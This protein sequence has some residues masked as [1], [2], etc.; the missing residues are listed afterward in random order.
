MAE[1]VQLI[2]VGGG[3][4]GT[5]AAIEG[6]RSGL[7]VTLVDEHPLDLNM[8]AQDIPLHFGQRMLGTVENRASML[9]RVAAANPEL[10][11]A[12]ELGVDVKL[13]TIVWSSEPN[14][15]LA[16]AEGDRSWLVEFERMI[17]ATGARD[18]G[19]AFP[20]W[21][22]AGVMGAAGAL[23]LMDRY[24]AFSGTSIAI[25]GSGDLGLHLAER[26]LE[27]GIQVVGIVDVSSEVR[28][29][30]EVSD[31]LESAGVP[32]YLSHRVKGA[33]GPGEVDGLA[34]EPLDAS[35][36][37]SRIECDTVCLAIGLVPSVELL[38]W[39]GCEMDY[40][41]TRGGFVPVLDEDQRTRRE[42][43]YV[44]GDAA[45]NAEDRY[46][47]ASFAADSG[48]RA[49][50]S[51]SESLG[52]LE[53]DEAERRKGELLPALSHSASELDRRIE[54]LES[55]MDGDGT[56]VCLCEEVTRRDLLAMVQRGPIHPDHVKRLTRAGMG[57]CQ[58]RRC[59][60]QI[61]LILANA[62]GS[63]ASE[64]PLASYR[65]PFRP[66]PL[67][68]VQSIEETPEEQAIFSN[69]WRRRHRRR[70]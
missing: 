62:T 4:A 23:T 41:P 49:A 63:A 52:A 27:R 69:R 2:V 28:G 34:I 66:L 51:V 38:Y 36:G 33:T 68:V 47:D 5:A 26:A 59:R 15:V 3:V 39:T 17:V 70:Q 31:R 29:S 1:Q 53:S 60:E 65:P 32:V 19:W 67:N 40:V 25:L 61:Q 50:L 58:G 42:D 6:A 55:V 44:A 30:K 24:E 54:W 18:F 14:N 10:E 11:T 48:K 57:Y 21:D 13:G 45:G 9:G 37:E 12:I 64:V 8:M 56:L 16:L 46:P 43:I 22:K 35:G 7:Q 20:G